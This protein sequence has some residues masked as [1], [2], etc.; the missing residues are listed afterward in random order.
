MQSVYYADNLHG[1][2]FRVFSS[3]VGAEEVGSTSSGGKVG[4]VAV[5]WVGGGV[6]YSDRDGGMIIRVDQKS[7]TST[8]VLDNLDTPTTIALEP[9][10]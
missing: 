6:F 4:G 2:V 3:G 1:S 10:R 9:Y 8:I 5:D 7:G